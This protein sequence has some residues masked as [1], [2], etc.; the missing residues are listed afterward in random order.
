M[1]DDCAADAEP[2]LKVGLGGQQV[3]RVPRAPVDFLFQD[4]LELVVEGDRTRPIDHSGLAL[5]Q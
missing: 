1:T 2:L 4:P 5:A 3:A